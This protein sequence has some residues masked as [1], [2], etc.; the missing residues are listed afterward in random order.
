MEDVSLYNRCC[1]VDVSNFADLCSDD[2]PYSIFHINIRS[3]YSNSDEFFI[4][5]KQLPIEPTIL[6][7]SET[8]FSESFTAELEGYSSFHVFRTNRRGG[9]VTI[10]V[11]S[12]FRS[13]CLPNLTGIHIYSEVSAV[14][15]CLG[16]RKIKVI[17]I[18]RPPDR[19]CR[20]FAED[21][22]PLLADVNGTMPT[23]IVG[24]FNL[25]LLNPSHSCSNFVDVMSAT[26][27]SPL[28]DIATYF[29]YANNPA[30]HDH[31]W[32]NQ[33]DATISGAFKVDISDHFPIFSLFSIP[34][35]S[36]D[37]YIKSFRDHSANSLAV[38]SGA[39]R[40]FARDFSASHAGDIDQTVH[41]F[42]D[43][44]YQL[45]DG[46][47]PI[48]KKCYAVNRRS[49]PWINKS[50][51]ECINRKHS[52]FRLYKAGAVDFHQYN[53]YK[54]LVTNVVRNSKVRYF[55]RKFYQ[56]GNDV[57]STWKTINSLTGSNRRGGGVGELKVG[58]ETVLE[59][60]DVADHFN[61]HFS[62]IAERIDSTIPPATHSFRDYM[63]APNPD[64][65]FAPPSTAEEVSSVICSLDNKSSD[66][67]S[68]PIF[69]YKFISV[70]ISPIISMMFNLSLEVGT[71][72][73]CLKTATVVPIHKSGDIN[74]VDNYRPISMLPIL[75][76]IFEKLMLR[77]LKSF[78]KASNLLNDNQFG[79]RENSSTSDALLEFIECTSVS[80]NNRNTLIA[81]FLDFSK[82]FDTV[83]HNILL[84]KLEHVG[85]RGRVRD[86]FDSYLDNRLQSVVINSVLSSQRVLGRGVP[87][88]SVLGPTLFLIYINDMKNC[89]N[90]LNL[91]HFADDTTAFLSSNDPTQLVR[92]ANIDLDNIK[93]WLYANRL[94][95]NIGKTSYMYICDS[96]LP[97]DLRPIEIAGGVVA[98]VDSSKF[99]GIYIDDKLNFKL[100]VDYICRKLS[101]TIGVMNRVSNLI[102]P[103]VKIK[104]Y[105]SL[106]FSVVSYGVSVWGKSGVVN[107]SRVDR[108]MSKAHRVVNYRNGCCSTIAD[109][110]FNFNDTY[111]YFTA[112]KLF[113]VIKFGFHQFFR[114]IL[115]GLIP[116]HTHSTR[117][118]TSG[119]FNPP[120]LGKSKCQRCFLYQSVKIWNDLPDQ[121]RNCNNLGQFKSKLRKYLN[122]S[123]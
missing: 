2:F 4:F 55:N 86:W 99:L 109:N 26:S 106:I 61:R 50:L 123:R 96:I 62:S 3:F 29:S 93:E 77:R 89:C 48:R 40:A 43:R 111:N 58:D 64:S 122:S 7:F 22:E 100:H 120:Q 5:I 57:K 117:L 20:T 14:E 75:S 76:K 1:Y 49:K 68:I 27:F 70:F 13:R 6:V 12:E 71:F 63:D 82:A 90:K 112:I 35:V 41:H 118:C 113:K 52:L 114:H 10:Y 36:S 103:E 39:I 84:G 79:F 78:L 15:V 92:D 88:G 8:W 9:G 83:C 108:L 107:A 23:F 45:Y 87:Q 97:I 69:I 105:F 32:Y 47:C 81:I 19:D 67:N 24:D 115:Q 104:M 37:K 121:I 51:I 31:I 60:L 119:K 95:L 11:K 80:L 74:C 46:C 110:L 65:M 53:T 17:G 59:P 72:P 56:N 25:D 101:R 16:G 94:S 98:R 73:A 34:S 21:I 54:N 102:C 85:V 44:I 66:I 116:N 28:I 91:I 18:Y 38:L 33:L 30:C 42:C